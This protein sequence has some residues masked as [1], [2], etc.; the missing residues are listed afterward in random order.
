LSVWAGVDVGGERKGFHAAVVDSESLQARHRS[1][2]A[3]ALVE[4]LLPWRPR[5]V[6]VDSP[7]STAPAGLSSREGERLL[8]R[9]GICGI[10]Y[11]PGQVE[12]DRNDYYEWIR[13]GLRLYSTL[14]DAGLATIECFPTASWS[15]L[16][17]ARGKERRSAW[18]RRALNGLGLGGLPPRLSQDD[19]DAVAAAVTARLHDAGATEA[20]G[21]IVV[22]RAG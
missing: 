3:E 19:R 8:V 2:S 17:G 9:A 10:R 6:A 11:T 4:W 22:P 15:R 5:L 18:T 16:A 20:F 13:N 12:V 21:E 14:K 1:Q 7:V